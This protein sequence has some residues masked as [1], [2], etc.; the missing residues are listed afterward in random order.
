MDELEQ[1][2][3]SFK[4]DFNDLQKYVD[5]RPIGFKE[6]PIDSLKIDNYLSLKSEI[7][8]DGL[9]KLHGS[10]S[11]NDSLSI[12]D[13]RQNHSLLLLKD[14]EKFSKLQ[15]FYLES[16]NPIFKAEFYD[17]IN[18]PNYQKSSELQKFLEYCSIEGK[19]N[20]IETIS[21]KML[22]ALGEENLTK[23]ILQESLK[24]E[25]YHYKQKYQKQV[26]KDI[27]SAT[28]K[29]REEIL[30][31]DASGSAKIINVG[32]L[33]KLTSLTEEQKDFIKTSW[34]Q[35]TF[36]SGW[37]AISC[38]TDN[39]LNKISQTYNNGEEIHFGYMSFADK[40]FL[41]IDVSKE[42]EVKLYNK[43]NMKVRTDFI[44]DPHSMIDCA[45]GI[46]EVDISNLQGKEFIP[47]C[48]S[49]QVK[50]NAYISTFDKN[51]K[52]DFPEKI[53][54]NSPE[55]D[56]K[57]QYLI[58]D[59]T[60]SY[61]NAL[62]YD[63]I[64]REDIDIAVDR[65]VTFTGSKETEQ[66][67]LEA[68]LDSHQLNEIQKQ[69][70]LQNI[71]DVKG[72][73]FFINSLQTAAAELIAK[74]KIVSM[75]EGSLN[76]QDQNFRKLISAF[77][78]SD[79]KNNLNIL[80][81]EIKKLENRREENPINYYDGLEQALAIKNYTLIE[82]NQN[83][84]EEFATRQL[85]KYCNNQTITTLN[86]DDTDRISKALVSILT[87]ICKNDQEKASLKQNAD[88]LVRNYAKHIGAT[89][90]FQQAWNAYIV[91]PVKKLLGRKKEIY[92]FFEQHTEIKKTLV[93][94]GRHVEELIKSRSNKREERSH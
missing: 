81:S 3:E 19:L 11:S 75:G 41:I 5:S 64:D 67:I 46:L 62:S 37:F 24:K 26:I 66:L 77:S 87:P 50:I 4:I 92:Q 60:E 72:D 29:G 83:K 94:K 28:E 20:S 61:L 32:E 84:I 57:R 53:I 54:A 18:K 89:M 79:T 39:L 6:S 63:V 78:S 69:L 86:K 56:Q 85:Q 58:R 73:D 88:L 35:G 51:I 14:L 40:N 52:F 74:E 65:L 55:F 44:N 48:A 1:V 17:E 91:D 10:L 13:L 8:T 27:G 71:T 22:L 30:Y 47:G 16:R 25:L 36:G 90:S 45:E 12:E 42:N 31:K 7:I 76:E 2:V 33:E 68:I 21:A 9:K 93:P 23:D 34:H 82:N 80:M 43:S 15:E 38:N 59:I 49:S 70:I